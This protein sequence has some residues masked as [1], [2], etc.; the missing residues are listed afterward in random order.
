MPLGSHLEYS[1]SKVLA[2]REQF[3]VHIAFIRTKFGDEFG[4]S[5]VLYDHA[6]EFF[7]LISAGN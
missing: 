6:I 5:D 3:S 7:S 4:F 1:Q 2:P